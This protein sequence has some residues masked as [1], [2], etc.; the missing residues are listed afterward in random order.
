MIAK[1]LTVAVTSIFLAA[2]NSTKPT[3]KAVSSVKPTP[4]PAEL[5]AN[6]S[7]AIETKYMCDIATTNGLKP[8]PGQMDYFRLGSGG[9]GYVDL[10][11][12]GVIDVVTGF[13]DEMFLASRF[14][15]PEE[16]AEWYEGNDKRATEAT[17]YMFFS[18]DPNFVVPNAKIDMAR[19]LLPGDLNGD[20]VEDLVFISM[21]QDFDNIG[22]TANFAKNT[23]LLSGKDGYKLKELPGDKSLWHGG[24]IGDLDNDGDLDIVA[25]SWRTGAISYINDGA[26]NFRAKYIFGK[27]HSKS[28]MYVNVT[29]WDI[30]K[31]GI[32]DMIGS[33]DGHHH[34][35]TNSIHWGKGNGKFEALPT[36]LNRNFDEEGYELIADN[37]FADLNGDGVEEII[38][39]ASYDSLGKKYSYHGYRVF[40]TEMDGRKVSKRTVIDEVAEANAWFPYFAACDLKNDGDID[41]VIERNGEMHTPRSARNTD[42]IV[43]ENNNGTF[44]KVMLAQTDI[45]E[46]MTDAQRSEVITEAERLGVAWE[47]YVPV[48]VYY[49]TSD[50]KRKGKTVADRPLKHLV[51]GTPVEFH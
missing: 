47:G 33:Q 31:D 30:D 26:G 42:K 8:K 7:T 5:N 37:V 25:V 49:P 35:A 2:C 1:I 29:L 41:L 22:S 4:S 11:G 20:G 24:S 46:N 36:V 32:L 6:T 27:P 18:P 21:K 50:G 45:Y 3:V 23:V 51:K 15:S 10:Y 17:Q 43:Y 38:S 44:T 40:I 19:H 39:L 28:K 9:V 12:D 34:P 48:Q 13:S 14:N 16:V